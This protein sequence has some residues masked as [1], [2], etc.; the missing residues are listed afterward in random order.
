MNIAAGDVWL[1]KRGS[2]A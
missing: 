1:S 2:P